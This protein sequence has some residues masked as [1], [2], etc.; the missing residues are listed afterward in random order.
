MFPGSEHVNVLTSCLEGEH[1]VSNPLLQLSL[2]HL[3]TQQPQTFSQ[4]FTQAL[5]CRRIHELLTLLQI[6]RFHRHHQYALLY[7]RATRVHYGCL[8]GCITNWQESRSYGH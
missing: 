2:S 1:S 7:D 6:H 8:W 5:R 4:A 3:G